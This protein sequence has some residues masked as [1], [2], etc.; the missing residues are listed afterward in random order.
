MSAQQRIPVMVSPAGNPGITQ[1][2]IRYEGKTLEE[3]LKKYRAHHNYVSAANGWVGNEQT[4]YTNTYK[5]YKD[6]KNLQAAEVKK[7][8][9]FGWKTADEKIARL[10]KQKEK[11]TL[12]PLNNIWETRKVEKKAKL[13]KA[14]KRCGWTRRWGPL[15]SYDTPPKNAIKP[16]TKEDLP[17]V[18]GGTR[19][20]RTN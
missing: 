3:A 1:D 15:G 8:G 13:E 18:S 5:K 9:T 14:R 12:K 7:R 6:L 16:C 17:N 20:K 2:S 11:A 10:Q 4:R 19:R